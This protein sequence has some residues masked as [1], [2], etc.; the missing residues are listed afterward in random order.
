M[1]KNNIQKIINFL[2]YDLKKLNN[3]KK[4][5]FDEIL[6]RNIP[7]NPIIFDV[8]ANKGQ[9]IKR[10]SKIF[11]NPVI[12][13]FEPLKDE[14]D[15][16]KKNYKKKNIILNNFA[17]GDKEEFKKFNIA[18][19]TD[20][21]SFYKIKKD[22]EW[23]KVRS[24]QNNTTQEDYAKNSMDVKVSTLDNYVKLN[25]IKKIDLLKIDTECHEDKVL[26]GSLRSLNDIPVNVILV[27][28]RFDDVYEKYFSFS[29]IERYIDPKKY[30]MVAIDLLN[31]NLFS[32][33][34]FAA[35]V[36]Y[37]DKKNFNI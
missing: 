26:E 13:S 24:E 34:V 32:G 30:R 29:E 18:T 28:I 11:N 14:F 22:T 9:S 15:Y 4:I 16:L 7:D 23:L 3:N 21:S 1:I 19:K 17:L 8:G 2:G 36:M 10:F 25:N 35:D 6:R 33:L 5:N 12:H 31:N 37:F 20:S 27:E